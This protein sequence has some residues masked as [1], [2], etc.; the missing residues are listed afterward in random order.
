MQLDISNY[1]EAQWLLLRTSSIGGSDV[2][3]ILGLN[4]YTTPVQVYLSKVEEPIAFENKYTK[5]GKK[6]EQIIA[7]YF[8]EETGC[9]VMQEKMM[10]YS[11]EYPFLS[12]NLDRIYIDDSGEKCILECK[13]V[14]EYYGDIEAFEPYISHYYQVLHYLYVTGYR[15]A[16]LAY[17]IKGYEFKTFEIKYEGDEKDLYENSVLPKLISFWEDNVMRRVPP[18]ALTYDDIPRKYKEVDKEQTIITDTATLEVY[19]QLKQCKK[20][21]KTLQEQEDMLKA[22]LA[23][24]IGKKEYLLN[25]NGDTL[26]TLKQSIRETFD[27]KAFR[28]DNPQLAQNY[29]KPSITRTLLLKENNNGC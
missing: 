23:D 19:E 17:L 27:S 6:Q 26:A 14:S 15:R 21:I 9:K 1:S 2:S 22:K 16:T 24:Y 18:S 8:A 7:D 29:I 11:E 20:D 3:S 28:K 5:A 10:Y 13:F 12:G 4:K 25:F